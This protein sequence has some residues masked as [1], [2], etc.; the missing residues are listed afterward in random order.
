MIDQSE[1]T[2]AIIRVSMFGFVSEFEFRI[3]SFF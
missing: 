3:S 1:L 2:V